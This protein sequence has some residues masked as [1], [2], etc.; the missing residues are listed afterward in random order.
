MDERIMIIAEGLKGMNNSAVSLVMKGEYDDAEEMFRS[1]ESTCRLFQ[2]SEGIGMIR[3]SLA[4]LSLIRGDVKGAM[5]HIE[6]ATEH[7]PEGE[8]RKEACKLRSK[9][10]L[11]ALEIGMGLE[12]EGDLEGALGFF[13]RSLPWLNEKRALLVADEIARIKEHLGI[14]GGA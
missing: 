10:A 3:V 14:D 12:K 6:V 2:Y 11:I 8:D 4:N 13:E 5:S 7:Y 9:I 1:A